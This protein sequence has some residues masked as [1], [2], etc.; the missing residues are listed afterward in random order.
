MIAYILA[1]ILALVGTILTPGV[2][3]LTAEDWSE[4][5]AEPAS[6]DW[7]ASVTGDSQCQYKSWCWLRH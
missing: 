3:T 6:V 1:I 5:L 2:L 7:A 4:M